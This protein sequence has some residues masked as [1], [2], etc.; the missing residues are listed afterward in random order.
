MT[1]LILFVIAILA[2]IGFSAYVRLAPMEA[3]AWHADPEDA[4][5]TG[6]P[7]DYM[8]APGGDGEAVLVD[9]SAAD[10]YDRVVRSFAAKPRTTQLAADPAEGRATFVQRSRLMGYPD[11]ISVRVTPVDGGS[12]LSIWSRSRFGQSDLGANRARVDAWI[13]DLGL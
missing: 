9:T 6:R 11:A 5:R 8:I 3:D 13:A 4:T 1:L 12:R 7:N 2:V 10:L